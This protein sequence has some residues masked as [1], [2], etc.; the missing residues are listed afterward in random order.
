MEP[1]IK[2]KKPNIILNFSLA[3]T[4]FIILYIFIQNW[5]NF[6]FKN[7]LLAIVLGLL[8]ALIPILGIFAALIEKRDRQS[9]KNLSFLK[10]LKTSLLIA[11]I[12]SFLT[13][14][15]FFAF[16]KYFNQNAITQGIEEQRK[17]M[18]KNNIDPKEIEK[19]T[20]KVHE[21]YAGYNP[22]T[23]GFSTALA[24]NAVFALVAALF[25]TTRPPKNTQ[26]T[27]YKK[28][29]KTILKWFWGK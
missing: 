4:L 3:I 22:L 11:I 18:Q 1:E 10:S 23:R 2:E 19:Q 21:Y 26:P 17:L 20:K 8:G 27:V 13:S 24:N 6:H 28:A 9:D 12:V 29:G 7:P 15:F 14:L 5:L 16:N 25:A